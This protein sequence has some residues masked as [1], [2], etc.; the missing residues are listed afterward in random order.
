MNA[1][2]DRRTAA[3]ITLSALLLA[4]CTTFSADGGMEDVSA[5]TQSALGQDA[6]WLR[7]D[8]ATQVA[9]SEVAALLEESL[10][11]GAAMRV[12]LLNNPQLQAAY[13]DLGMA[14]ADRVQAGRLPNPGFSFA[15]TSGG[16]AQEIE[17]GLHFNVLAV[18]TLPLRSGIEARRFEAAKLAAAS[19]T[20][21]TA[22]RARAAF[23]EA[24]AARQAME[25]FRQAMDA[26]DAA[27][28]LMGRMSRLGNSSRLDLARE[29]LFHAESLNALALAR[30]R[31][32][33]AREVLIRA[34]GLWGNQ[35]S[36][37]LPRRLPDLPGAPREIPELERVA[38]SQRLDVRRA[39]HDLDALADNLGLTEATRFINVLEAGP[40][41]VRERGEP[42][43]DGY[44]IALEIPIFDFGSVRVARARGLYAQA[45]AR[46]R[47]TAIA[48]RSQARDAYTGYRTAYDI[49][50][51]YRDEI[52]PVR[53]RISEEN[54]LRYNGMLIGVFEL[55]ADARVQS[56]TVNAYLDAL[57][58]FWLADNALDSALLIG[59]GGTLPSRSVSLAAGD[60]QAAH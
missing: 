38:V 44:E 26:A 17:R 41:Q 5:L 23:Y 27:R 53:K 50:R 48:A 59:T 32:T 42:I 12:A 3:A 29:Q 60:G 55:L 52:L 39:R 19:D 37:D 16:G 10:T 46:L 22:L 45:S 30:Q 28:D 18:L 24:V 21:A 40:A 36:F 7:D 11:P 58:A 51:N 35:A 49:A 54:L 14:E 4:G 34:L 2:N 20:I 15:K 31:E 33:S 47:G 25:Q 56:A 57:R 1:S 8:A 9:R 13:A 43:R 6:V